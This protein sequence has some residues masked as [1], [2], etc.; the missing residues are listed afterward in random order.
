VGGERKRG[1]TR[2]HDAENS[3]SEKNSLGPTAHHTSRNQL[4]LD[5]ERK[6]EE[7]GWF[8]TSVIYNASAVFQ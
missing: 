6:L 8:I 4:D 2:G 5:K 7:E 1:E 3:S